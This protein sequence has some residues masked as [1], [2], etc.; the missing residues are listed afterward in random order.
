MRIFLPPGR[1]EEL[2]SCSKEKRTRKTKGWE[3]PNLP[4]ED[5]IQQYN[6]KRKESGKRQIILYLILPSRG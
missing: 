2:L 3:G 6:K 4:K 5:N 1:Q